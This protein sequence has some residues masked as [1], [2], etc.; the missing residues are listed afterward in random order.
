MLASKREYKLWYHRKSWYILRAMVLR[1]HPICT[2]CI[3]A[4]D[5]PPKPS[6]VADHIVPHRGDWAKF[7]QLEN[8]TGL[9][10]R[11]HDE[12]TATEDGGFSNE[13]RPYMPTRRI[14]AT[15]SGKPE[16][17]SSTISQSRLDKAIGTKEELDELLSGIPE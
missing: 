16:F 11:H 2:M 10:K 7:C 6:T 17:A 4:G 3:A 15:G 1:R 8:L 13:Y 5:T 9:C 12:K 14:A